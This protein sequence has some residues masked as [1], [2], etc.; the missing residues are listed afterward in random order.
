MF[1]KAKQLVQVCTVRKSLNWDLINDP[2][3]CLLSYMTY[4]GQL[5]EIALQLTSL[6]LTVLADFKSLFS[7]LVNNLIFKL[8]IV[9]SDG[10]RKM[11]QTHAPDRDS[12]CILCW[13]VVTPTL[14][15]H[16]TCPSRLSF[17]NPFW[18]GKTWNMQTAVL[19]P[20][21]NACFYYPIIMQ[22]LARVK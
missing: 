3:L 16:D 2:W 1:T 7:L 18:T 13:R 20:F 9:S 17:R 21:N 6:L 12:S 15:T 5:H 11:Y 14:Q 19:T 8:H 22:L 4:L 10:G